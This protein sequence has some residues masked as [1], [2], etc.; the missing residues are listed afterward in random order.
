MEH[1]VEGA[2]S[3]QEPIRINR[4]TRVQGVEHVPARD[5]VVELRGPATLTLRA[6]GIWRGS[7]SSRKRAASSSLGIAAIL[8][9]ARA[10]SRKSLNPGWQL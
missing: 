8:R 7:I 3:G 9:Y 4:E 6:L 10:K 5:F 1:P 2:V